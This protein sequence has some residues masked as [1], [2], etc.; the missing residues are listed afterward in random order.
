[1]IYRAVLATIRGAH[2]GRLIERVT[3]SEL[4][5]LVTTPAGRPVGLVAEAGFTAWTVDGTVVI[6]DDPDETPGP[7]RVEMEWVDRDAGHVRVD[8]IV[9]DPDGPVDLMAMSTP[10]APAASQAAG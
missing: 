1:M 8:S 4:P 10:E 3:L 7:Y 5:L 6:N 9:L 2:D